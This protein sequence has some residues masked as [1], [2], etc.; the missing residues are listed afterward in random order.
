[1]CIFFVFLLQLTVILRG[2]CVDGSP[3]G[4]SP[5]PW[6]ATSTGTCVPT[7]PPPTT[8]RTRATTVSALSMPTLSPATTHEKAKTWEKQKVYNGRLHPSPLHEH[9]LENW[10]KFLQYKKKQLEMVISILFCQNSTD[11]TVSSSGPVTWTW[12]LHTALSTAPSTP[13]ISSVRTS[14][15]TSCTAV[16]ASPTPSG[17]VLSSSCPIW[18]RRTRMTSF[19]RSTR[20]TGWAMDRTIGRLAM[21]PLIFHWNQASG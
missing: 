16:Y 21:P 9:T 18:W 10:K 12:S 7:C 17:A 5:R 11:L 2:T 6:G 4:T 15:S 14:L 8:S 20:L 1:M 13:P 19:W 3:G